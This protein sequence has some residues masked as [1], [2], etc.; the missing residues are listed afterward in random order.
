MRTPILTIPSETCA[1]A[2]GVP[3]LAVARVAISAR[4]NRTALTLVRNLTSPRKSKLA[5]DRIQD[6]GHLSRVGVR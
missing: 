6:A 4:G 1:L 5:L 2:V 3:M